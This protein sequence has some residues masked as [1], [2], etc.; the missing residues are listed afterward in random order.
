MHKINEMR[1]MDEGM[2]EDD[3]KAA[4][5]IADADGSGYIEKDELNQLEFNLNKNVIF[6]NTNFTFNNNDKILIY[7]RSGCGKSTLLEII[8]GFHNL[9]D[10]NKL[11]INGNDNNIIV[12]II[13]L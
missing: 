3:I 12:I 6:K 11:L 10:N 9:N 8:S 13:Q 4:F 1:E 7:G 2:T 5:N